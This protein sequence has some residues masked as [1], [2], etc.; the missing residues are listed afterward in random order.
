[1][2]KKVALASLLATSGVCALEESPWLGNVYE[3][4]FQSEETYSRYRWIDGALKQPSYA[5]NNYVTGVGA[6][7]TSAENLDLGLDLEMARTPFQLYGFRSSA[8]GVRYLL[9]NDISGDPLSLTLGLNLRAVSSKSVRDVNSPYASYMNYEITTALGKEFSEEGNWTSRVQMLGSV[10]IANHGSVWNRAYVAFEKCF[11]KNQVVK[12]FSSGYVGYGP[13]KTI[14]ISDFH[15]W[16]EVCHRSID[17]G[18]QYRYCL[19]L[20]GEIGLSYAYRV[21]AISYPQNVQTA[22]L[23]YTL[24]FSFF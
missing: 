21:L 1:M 2:L 12:L 5:Y 22:E 23:S 16:G 17:C 14:D 6:S 3:F 18:I 8:L 10:G 20:W 15:G 24:P 13:K 4:N 11:F 9:L 7:F 19:N